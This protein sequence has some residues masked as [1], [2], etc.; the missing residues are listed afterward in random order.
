MPRSIYPLYWHDLSMVKKKM[1]RMERG[2]VK[3]SGLCNSS[4]ANSLPSSV[5]YHYIGFF[6][7]YSLSKARSNMQLNDICLMDNI[8]GNFVGISGHKLIHFVASQKKSQ[9]KPDSQ[10]TKGLH[11]ILGYQRQQFTF[12]SIVRSLISNQKDSFKG[13]FIWDRS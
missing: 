12:G 13:V 9:K 1:V 6:P 8:S 5:L 3:R 4:Y 10:K 7:T 11:I 2:S